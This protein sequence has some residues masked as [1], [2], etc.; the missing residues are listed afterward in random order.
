MALGSEINDGALSGLDLLPLLQAIGPVVLL[1]RL[2]CFALDYDAQRLSKFVFFTLALDSVDRGYLKLDQA[3]SL[4]D[5]SFVGFLYFY[6]EL[7][8]CSLV[9]SRFLLI[10][11]LSCE[12]ISRWM[13]LVILLAEGSLS[14]GGGSLTDR[15]LDLLG[16][17]SHLASSLVSLQ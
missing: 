5:D 15:K 8:I 11:Q 16:P 10:T 3:L 1:V 4:I 12:R 2:L 17:L 7:S 13:S 6:I 9:N 14:F